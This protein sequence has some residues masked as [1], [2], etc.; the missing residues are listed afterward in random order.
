MSFHK[1]THECIAVGEALVH[2]HGKQDVDQ[3]VTPTTGHEESPGRWEDNSDKDE[4]N[5]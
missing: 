4:N 5:V 1:V 2:L 3:Q